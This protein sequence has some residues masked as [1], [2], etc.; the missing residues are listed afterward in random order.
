MLPSL[1]CR[2]LR[3]NTIR[4]CVPT[5]TRLYAIG[6]IHGRADL[7]RRIHR[8]IDEDTGR[9][10]VTRTV[11]I[12]LGDYID[13]G[14]ESREVIDLMLDGPPSGFERI[15]LKGNHDECLAR[16]LVDPEIGELWLSHGGDNT[17]RS[18]GVIPPRSLLSSVEIRRAQQELRQALPPRH[19]AFFRG[20]KPAHV[21][22]DYFFVHAGI[23]PGVSLAYQTEEDMLWIGKEFLNSDLDHGKVIVHGHSIAATPD[24]RR[25][26]IGVDTGAY[27][28]GKLTC[29]VLQGT[30][31]LLLQT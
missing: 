20:L 5:G 9:T 19:V 6:D 25:N 31:R 24:V 28:T 30:T 17:L 26:R 22:G 18:Y 12:Y 4:P 1:L 23:R 29:L 15:H 8:L 21:E 13:R 11:V 3:H 10:P 14:M 27:A 16:F 7:L 2:V